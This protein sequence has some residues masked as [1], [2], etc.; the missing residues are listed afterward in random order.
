MFYSNLY[1]RHLLDMHI[2]QWDDS[3]LSRF[4]PEEY[5]ANL[6]RAGINYAML[7]LQSHVGL[8]YYPTKTGKM[9]RAFEKDPGMMQRLVELCHR[10]GIA[11]CGY[12]SLI[13]NTFEH[14]R[15]PDWRMLDHYGQSRRENGS[16][17]S[18]ELAFASPKQARY[19]LC[20][21]NNPAYRD[22]VEAQVNELMD[23]FDCDALFF[24]M[25]F[26]EHTCYCEHCQKAFGGPIPLEVTRELT[27][28]KAR[29][30]GEFAQ[31]VTSLVKSRRPDL[32][33]EH[34]CSQV[35]S[36]TSFTGCM[37]GVIN[38]C[39][40][41][42]GDLYGDLYNHSLGCKIYRNVSKNQPFE[43]MITRCKPSLQMHTLTKS[44]DQLK[45]AICSTMQHHG[46]TLLIDA[47]DPVGTMDSRVYDR[48]RELFAFQAQ[49][50]P[51]FTGKMVEQV[52]IYYGLR[53]RQQGSSITSLTCCTQAGRTLIRNH[54]PFGVTGSLCSLDD[55][56]IIAA[57][58]LSDMEEGD[59]RRLADFVEQG[60]TLYLS[61]SGN[62]ALVEKFTGNRI[63][64]NSKEVNVYV[65][66]K[67][68]WEDT[69][70]GFN[71]RYPLPFEVSAAIAKPGDGEVIATLTFPYTTPDDVRFA[72]IHSNPPGVATQ[73]PAVTV[74]RYGKGTVIWAALPFEN[75]QWEE[76][77]Q[78]FLKLMHLGK[79]PAY[80]FSSDAPVN[81]ELVAFRNPDSVTLSA[82]VLDDEHISTPALPFTVKVRCLAK[83]VTLVPGGEEIPFTV[84]DGCTVFRTRKLH[85]FDM[86]EL[87]L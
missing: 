51:W 61:G 21:P 27:E 43:Q 37:E 3:F 49:Y 16:L 74:S 80:F 13:Y 82:V 17:D 78:I 69:F 59:N 64:K 44:D 67:V 72:S 7:Y 36:P 2:D 66:P 6:K 31:W 86:Y 10:E 39:D 42:G 76:Y 48:L 70:S 18:N 33:V 81:V 68:G 40:Y 57:P 20:C 25:L 30:M 84:E 50:E 35:V 71:A 73:I 22:F 65:A 38:A 14:D 83:K 5:V 9:H 60:G 8:C 15:H 85:I 1:R 24:D 56:D 23:Y 11:V 4:D 53:S 46:A 58:W 52:G 62:A 26:W 54:I 63:L 29:T 45:T 75:M 77:R 34:N 41:V 55:Y 87:K 12:Y 19:G 28:F 47:I 32:P 79:K